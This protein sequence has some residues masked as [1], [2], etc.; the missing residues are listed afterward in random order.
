MADPVREAH[1]CCIFSEV[2][3]LRTGAESNTR[4]LHQ[5]TEYKGLRMSVGNVVEVLEGEIHRRH[6]HRHS[7]RNGHRLRTGLFVDGIATIPGPRRHDEKTE[8][9]V[10]PDMNIDSG[11]R[12]LAGGNSTLPRALI[13]HCPNYCAAKVKDANRSIHL[14]GNNHLAHKDVR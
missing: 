2:T 9:Y 6:A 10:D 13:S 14:R 12:G 3:C 1:V 4:S 11:E 7:A 8:L 5:D